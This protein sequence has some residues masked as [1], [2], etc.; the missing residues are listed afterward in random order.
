MSCFSSVSPVNRVGS[1]LKKSTNE[2]VLRQWIKFISTI[3]FVYS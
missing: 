1:F 3:L 2:E